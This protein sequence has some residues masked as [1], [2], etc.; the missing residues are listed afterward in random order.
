MKITEVVVHNYKSIC[1]DVKECRL[2]LDDKI[3]FLIG[4]NESGKTNLLEAMVKFSLGGFEDIDIPYMSP[5]RDEPEIAKDMKMVSVTYVLDKP[6]EKIVKQ[7]HP[8][9]A[10][11][12]EITITRNFTGEPYITSPELKVE[13]ALNEFLSQLRQQSRDFGSTLRAYIRQYKRVNRASATPTR[14]VLLRMYYLERQIKELASS[15]DKSRIAPTRRKVRGLRSAMQNLANPLETLEVEVL[16][17]LTDIEKAIE[18]LPEFVETMRVSQKLWKLVPQFTFVPADPRLWLTGEYLVDDI[19]AE[20]DSK[21]ALMSIR[22]LL[23]LANLDL[24]STRKLRAVSQTVA[25]ERAAHK[26]SKELRE[27]WEQEPDIQI[28][29]EWSPE[30]GNR[31][32]LIMVETAGHRGYPQHRSLGFRWFLEFYLLYSAALHKSTVLLFEEPGV[33]LH[34]DAQDDLKRVM[35]EKVATQCQIVYTTHFPSMYDLAY[36]EGCRAVVKDSGV[37]T[38]ETQY[39]PQHER[40]TWEVAMRALGIDAPF[41]RMCKRN[42][43]TEGP[44]DWIYLLTFAQ[45]IVPEEPRLNDVALGLIHVFPC[46]RASKIPTTVPYFFQPGVKSIILL[47]SDQAGQAARNKLEEQFHPPTE[48]I[49]KIVMVNDVEDVVSSLGSGEHELEDLLGIDYYSRL[50]TSWLEQGSLD[51]KDL[52]TPNLIASRAA[53]IVEHRYG[54]KLKK[55]ELA[56]HFRDLIQQGVTTVP[57]DVKARFH[58]LLLKV[59][60]GL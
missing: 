26:I 59:T 38:V 14:S 11:A 37:T 43:M 42:I 24:Q 34:P 12:N 51:A 40:V 7:V 39:S 6:D 15:F 31:K 1:S 50:V 54:K 20:P 32:L 19:I 5:Y 27:V 22:R 33:H 13:L 44:S 53:S 52:K 25:L 8:S 47:D 56:W 60:E 10:H 16:D 45:L 46:G 41:L 29:F 4:A 18:R 55:D 2:R 48:H 35:R 49:V 9:L 3:T 30:E 17:P 36:P 57:D 21:E 58:D 28:K 23:A